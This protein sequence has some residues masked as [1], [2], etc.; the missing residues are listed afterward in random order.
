MPETQVIDDPL[1]RLIEWH[2]PVAPPRP[3]RRATPD[4]SHGDELGVV[5]LPDRSPSSDS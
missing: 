4:V 2:T 3:R 5:P 1:V